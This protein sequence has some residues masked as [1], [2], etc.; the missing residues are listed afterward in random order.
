MSE[1]A[2]R[3]DPTRTNVLA[4]LGVVIAAA[5]AGWGTFSGDDDH[6]L[7]QYL[8]VVAIILVAAVIVFGI[9]IPRWPGATTALVLG[10]LSILSIA[11]FWTGLPPV[12]A[13]GAIA[14]GLGL[15][16]RGD[17]KGTIAIAL[18]ALAVVLDLVVYV[19]DQT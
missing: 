6:Q 8:V 12:L 11:V 4:A 14:L 10:G 9:V 15:R 7:R 1:Y 5:L 16:E 19:L 13:A 3:T 2:E 17:G 18:G